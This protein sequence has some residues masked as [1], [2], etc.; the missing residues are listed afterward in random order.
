MLS[1]RKIEQ[2][3]EKQK[4]Q[5]LIVLMG[6]DVESLCSMVQGKIGEHCVKHVQNFDELTPMEIENKDF[7][8]PVSFLKDETEL[9]EFTDLLRKL[10]NHAPL[11]LPFLVKP[12]KFQGRKKEGF[13]QKGLKEGNKRLLNCFLYD[14]EKAALEVGK[15]QQLFEFMEKVEVNIASTLENIHHAY[16]WANDF[17]KKEYHLVTVERKGDKRILEAVEKGITILKDELDIK[18]CMVLITG[19]EDL[20]LFEINDGLELIKEKLGEKTKLSMEK[21]TDE[22][23]K[24]GVSVTLAISK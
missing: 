24:E 6:E 2:E 7:I 23:R 9:E 8:L 19:P 14:M 15:D 1:R 18:E 13:Y 11:V 16:L 17:K 4:K 5:G 12:M 3:M 20:N 21:K 22:T 10:D